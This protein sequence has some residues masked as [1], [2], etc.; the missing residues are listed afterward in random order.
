MSSGHDRP[1]TVDLCRRA[2]ARR[3]YHNDI[4]RALYDRLRPKIKRA[5][6]TP[7]SQPPSSRRTRRRRAIKR[8]LILTSPSDEQ[9][10]RQSR[11]CAREPFAKRRIYPLRPIGT[12]SLQDGNVPRKSVVVLQTNSSNLSNL[13][14]SNTNFY[15]RH[16]I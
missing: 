5:F 7:T 11:V 2:A 9:R 10:A 8:A 12:V 15:A 4:A 3:R 13:L 16:I 1:C 6:R 14:P